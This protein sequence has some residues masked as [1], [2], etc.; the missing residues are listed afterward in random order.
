MYIRID[1]V[2]WSSGLMMTLEVGIINLHSVFVP[3]F[4]YNCGTCTVCM[5]CVSRHV[6]GSGRVAGHRAPD[7]RHTTAVR[8]ACVGGH[9]PQHVMAWSSHGALQDERAGAPWLPSQTQRSRRCELGRRVRPGAGVCWR[10]S[11]GLSKYVQRDERRTS[12]VQCDESPALDPGFGLKPSNE[13]C[14]TYSNVHIDTS[15]CF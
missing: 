14:F 4:R 3:R 7:V 10:R 11:T 12:R 2:T 6:V 5:M 15:G 1:T 13:Y 9:G 8:H